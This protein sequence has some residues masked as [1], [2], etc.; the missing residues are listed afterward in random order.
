M[1]KVLVL[2]FQRLLH[3]NETKINIPPIFHTLQI[4]RV[5]LHVHVVKD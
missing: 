5:S 4:E 1:E 2:L 3:L